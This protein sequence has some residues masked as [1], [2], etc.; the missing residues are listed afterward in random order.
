MARVDPDEYRFVALHKSAY[1][2]NDIFQVFSR[3]RDSDNRIGWLFPLYALVSSSHDYARDP[4][5]GV[6]ARC[7]KEHV[8]SDSISEIVERNENLHFAVLKKER[9]QRN[10]IDEITAMRYNLYSLGYCTSEI[11]DAK[12]HYANHD[13]IAN[14]EEARRN[15][16]IVVSPAVRSPSEYLV[17]LIETRLGNVEHFYF[18]FMLV[19]QVYELL[20]EQAFFDRMDNYRKRKLNIGTIREKVAELNNERKLMGI[21]FEKYR[22]RNEPDEDFRLAA[23]D[24]LKDFK[25][26]NYGGGQLT[27]SDLVY[28][29]R[30]VLVHNFYKYDGEDATLARLVDMFE[31]RSVDKLVLSNTT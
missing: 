19:Y 6:Y 12:K 10:G 26:E 17:R 22:V 4:H 16:K 15:K 20:M 11:D 14:V 9:L 5:W 31:L 8:G 3:N 24:F 18:R 2:E 1:A 30:N 7:L 21:L 23:I 27:F 13:I 25:E 29:I 28:D